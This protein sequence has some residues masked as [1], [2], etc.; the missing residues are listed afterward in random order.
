MKVVLDIAV[1]LSFFKVAFVSGSTALSTEILWLTGKVVLR[2]ER[3]E[4]IHNSTFGV[5]TYLGQFFS[6]RNSL[7]FR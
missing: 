5:K 3:S 1:I 4:K 2:Y 7:L 6:R